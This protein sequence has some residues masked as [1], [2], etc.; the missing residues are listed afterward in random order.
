MHNVAISADGLPIHKLASMAD[1]DAGGV[2]FQADPQTQA[3]MKEVDGL[4]TERKT[5]FYEI[6]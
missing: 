2:D 4:S 1:H 6:L 3:M 5:S